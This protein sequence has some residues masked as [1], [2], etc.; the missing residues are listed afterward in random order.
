H[1]RAAREAADAALRRLDDAVAVLPA[2]DIAAGQRL[3]AHLHEAAAMRLGDFVPSSPDALR[4]R[5]PDLRTSGRAAVSHLRAE[6]DRH[7]P[8]FRHAVRL[9]AAVATACAAE[10]YTAVGHGAWIALTVLIVLR[11]ETRSTYSRCWPHRGGGGGRGARLGRA[12]DRPPRSDGHRR[13]G[14]RGRRRSVRPRPLR[15]PRLGGAAARRSR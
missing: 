10:R 12:P 14:R 13:A 5:R 7:S 8:V 15:L 3:S 1:R 6:I 11:P 9:G 2:A 4:V